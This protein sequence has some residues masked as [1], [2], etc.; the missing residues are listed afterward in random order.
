MAADALTRAVLGAR[1]LGSGRVRFCRTALEDLDIGDW[2]AV[3]ETGADVPGRVVIAPRQ[4]VYAEPP[5]HLAVVVRRLTTAETEQLPSLADRAREVLDRAIAATRELGLPVFLTG[6]HPSLDGRTATVDWR[7]PHEY[8]LG[9]LVEVLAGSGANVRFE[10]EGPLAAAGVQLF[11]GLG[12]LPVRPLDLDAVVAGRFDR[13]GAE[14]TS[15]P[16]GLPRL[17]SRVA[18]PHGDGIL[19]SISTRHREALVRLDSGDDV[20]VPVDTLAPA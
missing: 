7:G 10:W 12:R 15:A 19:R 6:L 14:H 16:E 4:L 2:I 3:G 5:E 11:G 17:G 20:N 13:T 18:T 1:V 9:P 8:D